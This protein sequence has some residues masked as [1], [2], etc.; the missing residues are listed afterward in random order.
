V[1]GKIMGTND[2]LDQD[3]RYFIYKT[4]EETTMPPSTEDVA[5]HHNLEIS[6]V[7]ESF[8]RLADD[9]QIALAPGSYSI[10]M[11]HPFSSLPTNYTTEIGSK[12][13]FAN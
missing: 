9:H 7:E 6:Q 3:I 8:K 10:W 11:A 12:K 2:K 1:K 13:Y 5:K 4:F